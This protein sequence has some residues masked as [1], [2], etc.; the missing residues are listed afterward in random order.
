RAPG[1]AFEVALAAAEAAGGMP[2]ETFEALEF[3]LALGVDLARVELLALGRVADDLVRRVQFGETLRQLRIV[4]VGVGM[5]LLGELAESAFDRARIRRSRHA[6]D[7]IRV[8]HCLRNLQIPCAGE[9][10]AP[11]VNV[12]SPERG[13]NPLS[14]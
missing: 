2:T 6:K 3:R 5:Q 14:G 7:V 1:E 12:G 10:R 4:L 8:A 9:A 13:R 11:P